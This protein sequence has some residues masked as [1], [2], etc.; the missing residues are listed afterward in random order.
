[1]VTGIRRVGT[2]AAGYASTVP[3]WSG[4]SPSTSVESTR[5]LLRS[6][7][8]AL[9]RAVRGPGRERDVVLQIVKS[10]VAAVLAWQFARLV[11]GSE[12][13]FLAPLAAL[14]TVHA[15]VYQSLRGAAQHTL[16]VLA[17]V[18]LAFL[19]TRALGVEWWSLGL[20]L[21]LAL[22]VARWQRL[23]DSGL[24]VPTT[25]LLAMTIAGGVRDTALEARVLETL[26]GAVIGAATNLL[27]FPPVHLRSG[28]EAVASGAAGVARL[29]RSVAEGLRE[30]WTADQ[31][32]EWLERARHLDRLVRDARELT[33]QSRESLRFNPRAT[34]RTVPL[35]VADLS[36][37]VDSLEHV[38]VQCRSI[39][40]TLLDATHGDDARRPGP[41]FLAAYADVLDETAAA[42]EA[43]AD[44]QTGD[45]E[46]EN[47][48]GA[49][50]RGGDSWRQLRTRLVE[51]E[52]SPGAGLPTYG[53]L[54]VDAERM[55]DELERAEAAL[56][57]STP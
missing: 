15:T 38:A 12:Q 36:R 25:A 56:A 45:V 2:R 23:G 13:P 51:A 1:M 35:D 41:V 16:A 3:P 28:R 31:A 30:T 24:Q 53:S 20:V 19:A 22:V 27:V 29:L 6:R 46:R 8:R 4:W 5:R 37:A 52:E 49:V 26:V 34:P 43:L 48:R 14:I 40:S 21:V 32:Q 44:E 57:V 55:L 42:F 39:T 33:E 10:A 47:V 17:G 18:L 50:R 54:L 7:Q 9:G 11:M